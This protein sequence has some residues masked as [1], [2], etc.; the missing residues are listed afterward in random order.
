MARERRRI[1]EWMDVPGRLEPGERNAITDV[2]GVFVGHK[3]IWKGDSVRTGVTVIRPHGGDVYH[4][5]TPCAVYAGNGYGK[6]TG[7]MQVHEL[8]VLESMIGLTNTLSVPQVAQGILMAQQPLM[9]PGDG[10]MNVLVG[11]TNDGYLSDIRGFHVTPA[12]VLE[13][14]AA[15]SADV[16]EGAVGA[17]TGTTCYG[18][19]GGIGTASRVVR[20]RY[21]G[22]KK[23]YIVGALLQT[24]FGGNL[25]IYGRQLPFEPLPEP[26][27]AGS[28][29]IILATDAPVDARQ[30]LRIAKRGVVGMAMTGSYLSNGSGDF[31]VAFSNCRENLY[32]VR[33]AHIHMYARLSDSQL[34]P[35][36]EAAVDAAREA[37]YN[38][39]TMAADVAGYQGHR[40]DAFDIVNY[41]KRITLK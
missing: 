23:D 19:K 7:S 2:P 20:G 27:P 14:I 22:E 21:L 18:F 13:A 29:M 31:A 6:L 34:N 28:C 38:S 26:D 4:V 3:T 12:H 40:R 9:T 15:F 30:L 35:L 16:P 5:Q 8:G 1:R 10:T 41:A 11:E 36:F 25:N 33:D 39:L 24:N 32:D 37:V 17:G